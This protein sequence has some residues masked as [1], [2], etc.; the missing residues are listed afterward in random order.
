[1]RGER[2]RSSIERVN[3][4]PIGTRTPPRRLPR[5]AHFHPHFPLTDF[6]PLQSPALYEVLE[7]GE[8]SRRCSNLAFER[9][10]RMGTASPS[11]TDMVR[12][13]IGTAEFLLV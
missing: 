7:Y 11:W 4:V 9:V 6:S 2:V 12:I 3:I 1:M 5:T 10:F 13:R 8:F